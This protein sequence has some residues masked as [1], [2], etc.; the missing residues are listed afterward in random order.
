MNP[1][2]NKFEEL[3]EAT[4]EEVALAKRLERY[5][6]IE[7]LGLVRPDGTPVPK[8]WSVFMLGERVVVKDYTF[9]VG[10]IGESVLLL[11]P[12]GPVLVGQEP[13]TD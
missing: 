7:S 13:E 11:E 3:R 5:R 10:Y 9:K 6:D 1:D 4:S 8:H 2:S 12:L